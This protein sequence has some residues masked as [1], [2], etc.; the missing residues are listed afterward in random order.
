MDPKESCFGYAAQSG[1]EMMIEVRK[2]PWTREED[3]K[4]INC[5]AMHG[6][7]H[8]TYLARSA[9]LKRTG[10]SCR[11]RWVN[12]LHPDLKRENLTLQEQL[13]ILHLHS[14][15]GNRW[16]KIAQHLPG[17][18]DNEI[19]NY[20][21]TRVQK[22]AKQL[23]CDV[24]SSQFRDTIRYLRLPALADRVQRASA[25]SST[26]QPT[27][28]SNHTD[29]A[30]VYLPLTGLGLVDSDSKSDSMEAHVS[31]ASD[32]TCPDEVIV[33]S[34]MDVFPQDGPMTGPMSP[35]CSICNDELEGFDGQILEESNG[36]WLGQ[37]GESFN[38][39]IAND[40]FIG[41]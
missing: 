18:T 9:G 4:L 5:I 29:Y 12:Y 11:L 36:G 3:L 34:W 17:R 32:L 27:P 14:H 21:R 38:F 23:N 41:D 33:H 25:Q 13:L 8:W 24:N 7:A 39:L 15:W 20:W 19:K 10:K 1:E 22:L 16:S 28:S 40:F 26:A 35:A 2:G 37:G 30:T 31:P 6:P